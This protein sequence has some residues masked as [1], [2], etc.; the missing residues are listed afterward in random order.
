VTTPGGTATS[1]E[2]FDVAPT[3]TSLSAPSGVVGA[4]V[5]ING[6]SLLGVTG[7]TFS[8]LTIGSVPATVEPTPTPTNT[9]ITVKVPVIPSADLPAAVT[10]TLENSYGLAN[11]TASF[12][13]NP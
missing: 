7:V 4:L 10:I 6:N 3:I 1:T 2:L 9:Q 5:A 12:T 8:S 11:P 13:V